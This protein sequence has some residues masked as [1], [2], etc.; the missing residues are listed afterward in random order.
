M[1]LEFLNAM[2]KEFLYALIDHAVEFAVIGGH[3]VLCYSPLNRPENT[4]RNIGDLDILVSADYEN[5]RKIS[6]ALRTLRINFTVQQLEGA[7]SENRLPSFGGG[8][9]AQ[10]FPRIA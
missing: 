6:E 9:G 8:Y 10:L 7:F 5:L 2:E 4:P 3:A 1:T